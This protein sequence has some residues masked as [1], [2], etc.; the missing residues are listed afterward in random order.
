[1][2]RQVCICAGGTGGHL[3]P[4]IALAQELQQQDPLLDLLFVGGALST[5]RYFNR[6][7]PF[8]EIACGSLVKKPLPL[9]KSFCRIIQG[10]AESYRLFSRRRPD[11]LVGFGSYYGFPPL[12]AAWAMNIPTVL[13]AADAIPGRVVRM[14]APRA[15]ITALHLEAASRY[16]RGPSAIVGMPIRPK[17]QDPIAARREL[18]LTAEK[19]TLL[20]F[21][22]SQGAKMINEILFSVVAK[23]TCL[24]PLQVIHLTGQE[25]MVQPLK[26]LYRSHHIDSYV[27]A[28]EPNMGRVWSAT[29]AALCRSGASTLAELRHFGVPALLIP[30]P[31]ATDQHQDKNA[32]VYVALG[33]AIK[34]SQ[35][36]LTP[37]SLALLLT[38]LLSEQQ[39][40]RAALLRLEQPQNNLT[41]LVLEIL[42]RVG[43]SIG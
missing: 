42:N 29:T 40:M 36:S 12:L 14:M 26:E 17:E 23:L 3:F 13:Y 33:G 38:K 22:G 6:S 19:Q 31:Y 5:N 21:G 32:D 43:E 10:I 39:H 35:S 28:F 8:Q 41:D 34:A 9:F 20:I 25:G 30:Y 24:P 18:G 15:R 1:M 4:A 11:L 37:S 27:A 2:N 7:F 16:I